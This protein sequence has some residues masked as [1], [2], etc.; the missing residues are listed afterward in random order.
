MRFRALIFHGM[1]ATFKLSAVF[2]LQSQRTI[3]R[4]SN[5]HI[6]K[7]LARSRRKLFVSIRVKI[8]S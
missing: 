2:L 8:R 3:H 6:L 5:P 4:W 1:A 7:L